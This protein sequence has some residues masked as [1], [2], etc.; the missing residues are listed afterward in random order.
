MDR[1]GT[2]RVPLRTSHFRRALSS[3]LAV[4]TKRPVVPVSF[5]DPLIDRKGTL[6]KKIKSIGGVRCVDTGLKRLKA[7]GFVP[8]FRRRRKRTSVL[9]APL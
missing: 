1:A 3:A 4:S 6:Q 8:R 5:F 2:R 9:S 7:D